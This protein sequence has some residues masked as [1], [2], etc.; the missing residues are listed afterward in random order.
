MVQQATRPR[1]E[2]PA[3]AAAPSAAAAA[4]A[5]SNDP[6]E[7]SGTGVELGIAETRDQP[8][9]APGSG[10]SSGWPT[11]PADGPSPE[12]VGSYAPGCQPLVWEVLA[13]FREETA[14]KFVSSY[15]FLIFVV[16][17]LRM[18]LSH[19]VVLPIASP[20]QAK[21]KLAKLKTLLRFIDGFLEVFR[22]IIVFHGYKK[23]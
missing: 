20:Y 9:L 21:L 22:G 3:S 10:R 16:V 4:E 19:T 6:E 8:V 17:N 11:T 5:R 15:F 23:S 13:L 1:P 12:P 18:I 14:I 7:S 2:A